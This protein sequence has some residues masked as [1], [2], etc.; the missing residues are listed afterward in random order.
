[1]KNYLLTR[2]LALFMIFCVSAGISTAFQYLSQEN[3]GEAKKEIILAATSKVLEQGTQ[4]I[5]EVKTGM[6]AKDLS[7]LINLSAEIRDLY[8]IRE[9]GLGVVSQKAHEKISAYTKELKLSKI[10]HFDSTTFDK[11]LPILFIPNPDSNGKTSVAS[12][13]GGSLKIYSDKSFKTDP[14]NWDVALWNA[15]VRY[16]LKKGDVLINGETAYFLP[17][18]SETVQEINLN[19]FGRYLTKKQAAADQVAYNF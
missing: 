4:V 12:F 10:A 16:Y 15:Y 14:K 13:E 3:A 19:N 7:E 8:F 5:P 17:S 1:M 18:D 6:T 9:S 2:I 11:S